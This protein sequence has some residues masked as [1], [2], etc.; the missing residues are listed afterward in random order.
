MGYLNKTINWRFTGVHDSIKVSLEQ[1]ATILEEV[2]ITD[3]T[4]G[5]N[6]DTV[7]FDVDSLKS[8]S[9][10]NAR[11]LM[12]RVP[13][14]DVSG[15][16]LTYKGKKVS[17]VLIDNSDLSGSSYMELLDNVSLSSISSL[18]IIQ[19][20]Y[21]AQ[22]KQ[23]F[24]EP[25]LAIRL[26]TSKGNLHINPSAFIAGGNKGLWGAKLGT[27]TLA[28]KF[29]NFITL[30]YD[31]EQIGIFSDIDNEIDDQRLASG[32]ISYKSLDQVYKLPYSNIFPV[33]PAYNN[34]SNNL[35]LLSQTSFSVSNFIEYRNNVSLSDFRSESLY[36]M[37]NEFVIDST[38]FKIGESEEFIAKGKIFKMENELNFNYPKLYISLVNDIY[39]PEMQSNL[40]TKYDFDLSG[41]NESKVDIPDSKY[42]N[43]KVNFAYRISSKL[44]VNNDFSFTY[45]ALD[46]TLTSVGSRVSSITG[47]SEK[48]ASILHSSNYS[49][50]DDF[51]WTRAFQSSIFN[52]G[53]RFNS[54]SK[55]YS[56]E[57]S[58]QLPG[59]QAD[60]AL[61]VSKCNLLA[62]ISWDNSLEKNKFHYKI[63]VDLGRGNLRNSTGNNHS[64]QFLWDI[65]TEFR[66]FL[67]R[68][69]K[70]AFN[71]YIFQNNDYIN[72]FLPSGLIAI[73]FHI[74]EGFEDPNYLSSYLCSLSYM[75]SR[76][77]RPVAFKVEINTQKQDR[78]SQSYFRNLYYDRY[79]TYFSPSL[80]Y[81]LLT[82]LRLQKVLIPS[83]TTVQLIATRFSN[84]L[85]AEGTELRDEYLILQP[86]LTFDFS[87]K[88]YRIKW[89]NSLS[90]LRLEKENDNR[91]YQSLQYRPAVEL[92]FKSGD[93]RWDLSLKADYIQYS[94]SRDNFFAIDFNLYYQAFHHSR[95]GIF[96]LNLLNKRS[97]IV[98]S[99]SALNTTQHSYKFNGII[100]GLEYYFIL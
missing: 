95:F 47:S 10:R 43:Q 44:L 24:K 20:Y 17:K 51:Y 46:G 2:V 5:I 4:Y 92:D 59:F 22:A 48:I 11:D 60:N 79:G 100:F 98:D 32:D 49:I 6:I 78:L 63:K 23:F 65:N 97:F 82:Y 68:F 54:I 71:A 90:Y 53:I 1:G 57:L 30:R 34:M 52:I 55:S 87:F 9:T 73:P 33:A 67:N 7:S 50:G 12:I 76:L 69:N 14:M 72:K 16:Y 77:D 80:R 75:Y 64:N 25:E 42:I 19:N 37:T 36:N 45:D 93:E 31:R 13:G 89:N 26:N 62:F 29:K 21:E 85:R 86:S 88:N 28:Q 91:V 83:I 61:V 84:Q 38:S 27:T 8:I 96:G 56:S 35:G 58:F 74:N 94:G 66:Y 3:N 18:D 15:N 81:N 70:I 41:N 40:I 99:F 39:L